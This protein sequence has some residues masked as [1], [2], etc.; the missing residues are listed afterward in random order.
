MNKLFLV[1][2][3]GLLLATGCATTIE[4]TSIPVN[5]NPN[6]TAPGVAP[7][8]AASPTVPLRPEGNCQSRI[9]GRVLDSTGAIIKGAAID[10]RGNGIKGTPPKAVSDDNGLYG[11]AGLCAGAY[12]FTV[13]APGKRAVALTVSADVDGA[14]VARADL[15]VK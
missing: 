7:L 14:N 13:T 12:T 11:F 15:T 1:C 6:P 9:S 3:V 2:L 8:A 10:L 4:P 5:G